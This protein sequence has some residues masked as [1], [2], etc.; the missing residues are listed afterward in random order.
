MG[1]IKIEYF[2]SWLP[3]SAFLEK[4]AAGGSRQDRE[5]ALGHETEASRSKMKCGPGQP[6]GPHRSWISCPA[7]PPHGDGMMLVARQRS[8]SAASAKASPQLAIQ[9]S[10][11][12]GHRG[13]QRPDPAPR[14]GW[15]G[16]RNARAT[17][18][19]SRTFPECPP[20]IHPRESPVCRW[21][22]RNHQASSGSSHV[23][24]EHTL[25]RNVVGCKK[26]KS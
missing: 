25:V 2:R 26:K 3:A 20:V 16:G 12:C 13:G 9:G 1:R 23:F 7:L 15:G 22:C 17:S 8:G 11:S 5:C 19:R 18:T 6:P 10:R 4:F 14:A 24:A 21:L